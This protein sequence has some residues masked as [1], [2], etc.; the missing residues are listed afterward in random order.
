MQTVTF[1]TLGCKLNQAETDAIQN[2]FLKR[3]FVS[4]PFGESVDLTLIN[5][6]CVTNEAD[7]KSRNAIRQAVRN[8][9]EGRVVVTGCYA[10]IKPDEIREIDG[11]D[12]VLGS[13]EKFR[14]FD[15]LEKLQNG[16]L[17]APLV[18]VNARG[19]LQE[20]SPDGF[21]ATTD[22]TRAFLKIQDGC[23][24][25]CSFCII[26]FARGR[27]RSRPL[28]EAVEETKRLVE[29]GYR[30]I[31]MTGVNMGTYEWKNGHTY[32]FVDLIDALQNVDGLERIR[33]SSVEPN[34]ISLDLFKLA[35]QSK[36][37]C[38]HFHIPLQAGSDEILKGMKRRYDTD[39]FAA[40]M[41]DY[42]KI[43]PGGALGTDVIVGFPGESDEIFEKSVQFIQKQPFTYLHVFRFSRRDG[44]LVTRLADKVP[45]PIAKERS[46]VL[47]EV[48]KKIQQSYAVQ[49]IGTTQPVL[50]DDAWDVGVY[51]GYTPHYLRV[52][53]KTK[54]DLRNKVV[55][56]YLHHMPESSGY[57]LGKLPTK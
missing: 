35:A 13:D 12:L 55:P 47:Q 14:I 42:R 41:D 23:N 43:L 50:F 18:F 8:S 38:P 21:V 1:K 5:T 34:T 9:P 26:P 27:A 45:V 31:V 52:H 3:G 40:L 49:F 2:Q 46:R 57:I 20:I 32:H 22:R 54:E 11:V 10:Q 53:L 7:G 29:E 33:I 39:Y 6:C 25:Y 28:P 4:R 24:F 44:T 36:V 30:E 48:S 17:E 37:I 16:K 56:V 19:D 51:A 15:H